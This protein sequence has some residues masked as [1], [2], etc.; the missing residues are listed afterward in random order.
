MD[1]Q[2]K[3][4]DKNAR[5]RQTAAGASSKSS[6]GVEMKTLTVHLTAFFVLAS[7]SSV[8]SAGEGLTTYAPNGTMLCRFENVG[9]GNWTIWSPG[10]G[11]PEPLKQIGQYSDH[12]QLYAW[13]RQSYGY[14][15]YQLYRYPYDPQLGWVISHFPLKNNG[16]GT[17]GT[18][19]GIWDSN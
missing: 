14:T 5:L 13:P 8:A 7:L 4:A 18:T 2:L 6:N 11:S 19:Q 9:N 16:I 12:I 1:L 10:W 15:W 3:I 17:M